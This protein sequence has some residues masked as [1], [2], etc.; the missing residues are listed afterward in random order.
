[1][2]ATTQEIN[3]ELNSLSEYHLRL[4]RKDEVLIGRTKFGT[5]NLSYSDKV[6]RLVKCGLEPETIASGAKKA[7]KEA[8]MSAYQI[9]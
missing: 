7:V 4:A 8:L 6:Y 5:L 3:K 9:I 1:M 2:T